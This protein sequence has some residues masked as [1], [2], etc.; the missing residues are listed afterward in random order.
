MRRAVIGLLAA[1]F[2][3]ACGGGPTPE[4]LATKA[5]LV[6]AHVARAAASHLTSRYD[7]A[8]AGQPP[9][10]EGAAPSWEAAAAYRASAEGLAAVTYLSELGKPVS[11]DPSF[12]RAGD[13]DAVRRATT[14]L[15][16]IVLQPA[17]TR[18]EFA[19]RVSDAQAR[20]FSAVSALEKGTKN[21]ILI[22][23]R[24]ES[25]IRMAEYTEILAGSRAAGAGTAP[26]AS[27]TP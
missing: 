27:P 9:A 19:A 22:E 8:L 13:I 3:G 16:T 14:E 10:E 11:V 20:L 5:A 25:N 2:A 23:T 24:S 21:H 7:E 4:Q 15:V 17:G 12:P 26:G 1:L 18:E 6:D